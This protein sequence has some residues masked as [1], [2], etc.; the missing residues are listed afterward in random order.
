MLINNDTTREFGVCAYQYC[1]VHVYYTSVGKKGQS[2]VQRSTSRASN[3]SLQ[4][5]GELEGDFSKE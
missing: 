2:A 3:A 1:V 5:S 4:R